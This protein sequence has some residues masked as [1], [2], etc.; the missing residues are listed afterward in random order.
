MIVILNLL[1]VI[2]A[3]GAMALAF[4]LKK[5]WPAVVAIVFALLYN[6]IQPSYMPKGTI[7]RTALPAFEQSDAKIEDRLL[8]PK[9]GVEYDAGREASVKDGLKFIE[10]PVDRE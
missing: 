1:V 7:A 5:I 6:F 2:V 10:K 8:A 4:H 3:V 9:S